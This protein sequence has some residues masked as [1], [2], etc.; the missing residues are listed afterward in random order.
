MHVGP[1]AQAWPHRY[2]GG[3]C[4]PLFSVEAGVATLNLKVDAEACWGAEEVDLRRVWLCMYSEARDEPIVAVGPE[5]SAD[6][7]EGRCK[8]EA[9]GEDARVDGETAE[10]GHG[11]ADAILR[12]DWRAKQRNQRNQRVG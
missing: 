1:R 8:A 11:A 4:F 6:E 7:I 10:G 5:R 2:F 12:R 3:L 9:D